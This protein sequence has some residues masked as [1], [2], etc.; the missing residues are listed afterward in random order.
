[1]AGKVIL[2]YFNGRGRMESIRWLLAVAE[3]KASKGWW[4]E[5]LTEKNL[6]K[7]ILKKNKQLLRNLFIV[8]GKVHFNPS[9]VWKTSE[10][11]VV[12]FY[13]VFDTKE[14][15]IIFLFLHVDEST[16]CSAQ[17]FLIQLTS[18]YSFYNLGWIYGE[19]TYACN[20]GVPWLISH[21]GFFSSDGA[22]MFQQL[23][24]VEIDGM[25]LVQSKAIMN[26]ISEKY[27]L[28]GNDI[29]ERVMYVTAFYSKHVGTFLLFC[30]I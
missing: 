3:V 1:M 21:L 24:L 20:L 16:R 27:N 26:Y 6:E 15:H 17:F 14:N 11:W 9:A 19:I 22:L 23:P 2:H 30:N 18:T 7:V 25:K 4:W 12:F 8:W 13:I 5:K 10:W 28:Y 29:K